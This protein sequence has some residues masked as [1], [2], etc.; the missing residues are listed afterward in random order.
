[1][2]G[3]GCAIAIFPVPHS[4]KYSISTIYGKSIDF[5]IY[6][7]YVISEPEKQAG[8]TSAMRKP[9]SCYVGISLTNSVLAAIIVGIK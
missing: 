9:S 6:V 2:T 5:A 4:I 8:K 3:V 7:E 1:L